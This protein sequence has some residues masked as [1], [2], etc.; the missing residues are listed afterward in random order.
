[1]WETPAG[2]ECAVEVASAAASGFAVMVLR[3]ES[4]PPTLKIVLV[5]A[6]V[7]RPVYWVLNP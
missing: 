5:V 2:V 6:A 7:D 1:M 3:K 4:S